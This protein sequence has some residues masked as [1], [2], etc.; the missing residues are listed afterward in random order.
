MRCDALVPR[1]TA[2]TR[3]RAH[4][5]WPRSVALSTTRRAIGLSR[6]TQS[7][8]TPVRSLSGGRPR[9]PARE[10]FGAN[11][12][13]WRRERHPTPVNCFGQPFL[14]RTWGPR[15][16]VFL[17]RCLPGTVVPLP[18]LQRKF[19]AI[20]SYSSLRLVVLVSDRGAFLCQFNYALLKDLTVFLSSRLIGSVVQ[21][22]L[23]R[24]Y[25][26]IKLLGTEGTWIRRMKSPRAIQRAHGGLLHVDAPSSLRLVCSAGVLLARPPSPGSQ[27]AK[28]I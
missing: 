24:I 6:A 26:R 4:A 9:C 8:S 11:D 22:R 7:S 1:A 28:W 13:S 14:L 12:T 27:I 3:N 10:R 19:L 2:K 16:T 17:S 5:S 18:I 25:T 15:L 20:F 23:E 21:R